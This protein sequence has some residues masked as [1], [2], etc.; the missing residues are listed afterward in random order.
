[1]F[2]SHQSRASQ[3]RPDRAHARCF[4]SPPA[5]LVELVGSVRSQNAPRVLQG[6][7]KVCYKDITIILQG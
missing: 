1:M 3:G 2:V 5:G 4:G 6:C 7:H